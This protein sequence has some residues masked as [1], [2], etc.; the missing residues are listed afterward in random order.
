[1]M[2]SKI[3][4]PQVTEPLTD[5]ATQVMT[6]ETTLPEHGLNIEEEFIAN[7][8]V[9]FKPYHLLKYI[10]TRSPISVADIG[11]NWKPGRDV[12]QEFKELYPKKG[13]KVSLIKILCNS[14]VKFDLLSEY[15]S[16][17]ATA[18]TSR[19]RMSSCCYGITPQGRDYLARVFDDKKIERTENAIKTSGTDIIKPEK[20]K[21]KSAPR[22]KKKLVMMNK[23]M[24]LRKSRMTMNPS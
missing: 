11:R 2:E 19:G 21:R 10:S 6:T 23:I 22:K 12:Q 17:K 8:C 1:M 16:P 15:E 18:H 4:L 3:S 14:L 7:G 20:K 9:M 24:N 13:G 5:I